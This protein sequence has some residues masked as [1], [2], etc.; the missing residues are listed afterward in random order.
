MLVIMNLASIQSILHSGLS[1]VRTHTHI[2]KSR[3]IHGSAREGASAWQMRHYFAIT[4]HSY[5]VSHAMITLLIAYRIRLAAERQQ[6][7]A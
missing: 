6:P 2:H 1:G 5:L 3:F 4:T 7:Y